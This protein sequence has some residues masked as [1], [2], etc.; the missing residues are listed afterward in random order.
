MKENNIEINDL[1]SH[2]LL[3][4]PAIKKKKGDVHFTPAGYAYL[5]EKVADT[6][7]NSIK[8]EKK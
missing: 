6:I 3:K 2:A 5:A 1:H 4:L 8:S 7:E